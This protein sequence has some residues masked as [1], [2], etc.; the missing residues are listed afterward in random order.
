MLDCCDW[1][2]EHIE[3]EV[4]GVEEAV[5]RISKPWPSGFVSFSYIRIYGKTEA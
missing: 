4:S 2:V 1:F 5:L 3:K